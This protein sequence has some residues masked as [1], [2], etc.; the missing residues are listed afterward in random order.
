MSTTSST[1]SSTSGASTG[2]GLTSLGGSSALQVTGL[3]S[4]L[5]TD[6]IVSE[7]M[8]VKE[9]PLTALK[10][11]E[12]VLEAKN[13]AL[14]TLQ[15]ELQTVANDARALLSPGLYHSSQTVGSSNSTLVSATATSS[16]GA[17]EGGY[18]VAVTQLAQSAQRTFSYSAPAADDTVTVDGQAVT[19]SAGESA[20]DF[21]AAVNNNSSLD[22]YATATDSGTIV[23]SNRAT[24]STGGSYIQVS[25]PGGALAEQTAKAKD[26]QDAL[27]SVDGVS[28]SSSSN[29]VTSAIPGVTLTLNALTTSSGPVTV[30]VNA[31]AVASSSIE[32]ALHQFTTD[33]NK[34]IADIQ[35]QLSTVPADT[36]GTETGTL[37]ND[38]DLKNLLTQ[39]R[40]AMYQTVSGTDSGLGNLVEL[41]VSTGA[42]TGSGSPSNS[43]LDGDLALNT[44]TLQSAL[45]SDPAGV[46][47]LLGGWANSFSSLVGQ[48]AD[49]GGTIDQRVSANKSQISQLGNQISQMQVS[50]NDQQQQLVKQFA[51]MESALSSTQSESNWLTQQINA[52]TPTH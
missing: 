38:Q 50:L 5:D 15:S 21:A 47:K 32:S 17:V 23:F 31:P 19:I 7:L 14:A 1:S 34:A 12:S 6:A 16:T 28:G 13:T 2:Y 52:L 48:E 45:S 18:Q 42:T 40:S 37:Y 30:N 41:G 22:V 46:Q 51:A 35:T 43:S 8:Q 24:G 20:S 3:S 10:N 44:S 25:D 11:Q 4:G 39:M 49:T 26:G 9:R 36:D 27:Y 29:T 33:Y